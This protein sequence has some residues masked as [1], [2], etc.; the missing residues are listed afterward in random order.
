MRFPNF[1][2]LLFEGA[3]A[4]IGAYFG[5]PLLGITVPSWLIGIAGVALLVSAGL[6]VFGKKL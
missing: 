4:T 1:K 2:I 3:L 5:L 6:H